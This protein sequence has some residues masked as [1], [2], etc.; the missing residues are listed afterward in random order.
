MTGTIL[1]NIHW[2]DHDELKVL[3]KEL[4]I[5]AGADDEKFANKHDYFLFLQD[6]L[7]ERY[8]CEIESFVVMMN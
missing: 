5:V 1:T 2:G 3:P 4:V 6:L 8:E 7:E